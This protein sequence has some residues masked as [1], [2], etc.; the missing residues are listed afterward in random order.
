MSDKEEKEL[1]ILSVRG[2]SFSDLK[3]F[4]E[5]LKKIEDKLPYKVFVTNQEIPSI[6]LEDFK[7]LAK[8]ILEK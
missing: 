1:V 7:R 8:E 3:Q 4:A 2:A 6:V 5:E